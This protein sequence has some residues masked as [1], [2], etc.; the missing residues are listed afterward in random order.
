MGFSDGKI[1]IDIFGG[2]GKSS[3]SDSATWHDKYLQ[4]RK[5]QDAEMSRLASRLND[6]TAFAQPS[7]ISRPKPPTQPPLPVHE[8]IPFRIDDSPK[9]VRYIARETV[10]DNGDMELLK[11]MMPRMVEATRTGSHSHSIE[12]APII[13][14]I[15]WRM[16]MA[17]TFGVPLSIF[18]GE[19]IDESTKTDDLSLIKMHR[20]E[21]EKSS[22]AAH[23]DEKWREDAG[24]LMEGTAKTVNEI[25]ARV[26]KGGRR[27]NDFAVSQREAAK[28]LTGLGCKVTSRTI[29]NW[30]AGKGTPDDY[31]SEKRCSLEAFTAW[32]KIYVAREKSKLNAKKAIAYRDGVKH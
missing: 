32:A 18:E 13:D 25:A 19:R 23:D 27:R 4:Y 31:T 1:K 28:I 22:S 15:K 2:G 5:Q 24:R 8:K 11:S 7:M 16:K 21:L 9:T 29:R 12:I 3:F 20:S 6:L 14:R 30:E 17:E 26:R 10:G